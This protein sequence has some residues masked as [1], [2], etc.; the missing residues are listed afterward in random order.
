MLGQTIQG[1]S[2]DLTWHSKALFGKY[3]SETASLLLVTV[4]QTFD[5]IPFA[6]LGF[7]LDVLS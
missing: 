1:S 6:T 5:K 3:F 4:V 2:G 7:A